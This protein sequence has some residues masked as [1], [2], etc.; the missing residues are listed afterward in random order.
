MAANGPQKNI[1]IDLSNYKDRN[2]ARVPEG[3]Y[4]LQI[5]DIEQGTSSKGDPMVTVFT[6]IVGGKH[7]GKNIVDRLTMNDKAMFRMVAFLQ[8]LNIPTPKG[9]IKLPPRKFLGQMFQAD[10]KDEK[11]YNGTIKSGIANYLEMPVKLRGE[12]VED[13][14][15]DEDDE[16]DT[17]TVLRSKRRVADVADED[18]DDEAEEAPA[19][20]RRSAAAVEVDEDEV[21]DEPTDYDDDSEEAKIATRKRA[22][23]QLA[24]AAADEDEE[25]EEAPVRTRRAPSTEV[26]DE[27]GDV[28]V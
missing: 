11:P 4:T 27:I 5:E 12:E 20:R 21:S 14:E 25:P 13:Q 15:D 22:A 9:E 18:D 17:D 1:V 23:R 28:E 24:E 7:A 19:P 6:R 26:A 3:R 2:S 8:A 10:L 16:L